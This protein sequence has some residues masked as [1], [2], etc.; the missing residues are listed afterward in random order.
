M[1]ENFEKMDFNFDTQPNA[2]VS[3]YNFT[4]KP[5]LGHYELKFSKCPIFSFNFNNLNK[6]TDL[7]VHDSYCGDVGGNEF[8]LLSEEV[9]KQV[10]E[11]KQPEEV[12]EV[13]SG[14]SNLNNVYEGEA[15]HNAD[16]WDDNA[17]VEVVNDYF[18]DENKVLE[19]FGKIIPDNSN[20]NKIVNC[21]QYNNINRS[22]YDTDDFNYLEN[23]NYEFEYTTGDFNNFNDYSNTDVVNCTTNYM[24]SQ[25]MSQV[26]EQQP[27]KPPED[28]GNK[29][30]LLASKSKL[31]KN[32]FN[33]ETNNISTNQFK[34]PMES[35]TLCPNYDD[36]SED[37]LKEEIKQYGLKT[38][39][40]KNMVRQ[41]KDIWAFMNL[42][43]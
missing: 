14:Y 36:C 25:T 7:G 43:I 6:I 27:I 20:S 13:D 3:F 10:E 19:H 42:S 30:K 9:V 35:E 41:L 32:H 12:K 15:T 24:Y 4:K 40:N 22:E 16:L 31:D 5:I 18:E 38:G 29:Y 34:Q 11:I 39:S 17:Y 1:N 28:F 8:M 23:N 21:N 33:K 2:E 37:K 26:I